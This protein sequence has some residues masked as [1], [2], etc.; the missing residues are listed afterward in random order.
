MGQNELQMGQLGHRPTD[1]ML[2][3][4]DT[5]LNWKPLQDLKCRIR[6]QNYITK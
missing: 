3:G 5:A 1:F 2:E 6:G 4:L